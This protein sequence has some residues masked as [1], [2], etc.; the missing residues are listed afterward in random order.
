VIIKV[1]GYSV[2]RLLNLLGNHDILVWNIEDHGDYHTMHMSVEGFFAL[3]PLL[4][5]TKTKVAA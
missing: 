5:K 2:E 4:K 3:K 1:W